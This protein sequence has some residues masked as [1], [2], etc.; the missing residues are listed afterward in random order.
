MGCQNSQARVT[1][2]CDFGWRS[3][4]Q[5][6]SV[7]TTASVL[8]TPELLRSIRSTRK[9]R[10]TYLTRYS[11]S[12]TKPSSAWSHWS[13]IPRTALPSVGP[14]GTFSQAL[15]SS[16]LFFDHCVCPSILLLSCSDSLSGHF[17]VLLGVYLFFLLSAIF[18]H[19]FLGVF[20]H[21]IIGADMGTGIGTCP[22]E[23]EESA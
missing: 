11:G 23:K 1:R 8:R 9:G 7:A 6:A 4:M 18:L 15:C 3:A 22:N 14:C 21:F 12:I 10:C 17:F 2:T 5:L 20:L 13:T 19:F 16:V